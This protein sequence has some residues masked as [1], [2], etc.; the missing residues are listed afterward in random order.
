MAL[1]N[2]VEIERLNV[3]AG[4]AA[5]ISKRAKKAA[6]LQ[7]PAYWVSPSETS[8]RR[9]ALQEIDKLV[10]DLTLKVDSLF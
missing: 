10:S 4:I 6:G 1:S 9:A 8:A 3:I 5:E 7:G 2:A